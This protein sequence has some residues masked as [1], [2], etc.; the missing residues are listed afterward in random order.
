MWY[1]KFCLKLHT[2]KIV[3]YL[4]EFEK[5]VQTKSEFAGYEDL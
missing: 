1:Y 2:V 4:S 5:Q 3:P